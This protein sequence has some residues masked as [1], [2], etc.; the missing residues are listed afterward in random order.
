M[1][2]TFLDTHAPAFFP[3]WQLLTEGR[4]CRGYRGQRP[5][6]CPIALVDQQ[7]AGRDRALGVVRALALR[8]GPRLGQEI[9]HPKDLA[10]GRFPLMRINTHVSEGRGYR[11]GQPSAGHR[12]RQPS[13]G[14]RPGQPSAGHHAR[15]P[16]KVRW[17]RQPSR[18]GRVRRPPRVRCAM[19]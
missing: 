3:D 6:A 15:Q 1:R 2:F 13:A 5:T 11:P 9:N 10:V 8:P 4:C 7:R 17:V 14:H 12:P 19:S 18:V 16:S